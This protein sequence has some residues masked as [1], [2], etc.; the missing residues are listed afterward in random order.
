M[1]PAIGVKKSYLNADPAHRHKPAGA[2]AVSMNEEG[3]LVVHAVADRAERVDASFSTTAAAAES[4]GT[5]HEPPPPAEG[6]AS[7]AGSAP[8]SAPRGAR[9]R[10]GGR[11]RAIAL[12]RRRKSPCRLADART[13]H[14]CGRRRRGRV[15]RPP[16]SRTRSV[17]GR[18]PAGRLEARAPSRQHSA[19]N[20]CAD[21]SLSSRRSR[22][23][24]PGPPP[25]SERCSS[26]NAPPPR[27]LVR[28]S[29]RRAARR[30]PLR[31]A[32]SITMSAPALRMHWEG[33]RRSANFLRAAAQ[34][35]RGECASTRLQIS[36]EGPGRP[37]KYLAGWYF[38]L[39]VTG[40]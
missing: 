13:G 24:P 14:P 35:G 31:A 6:A 27:R 28:P 18:P 3:R 10:G 23:R 4:R 11:P 34:R 1:P 5:L 20:N 30:P 19:R 21:A 39:R 17:L 29:E 7:A 36:L 25:R 8:S 33:R 15:A 22:T 2:N 37:T 32:Q 38:G 40:P 9:A 12:E 26:S 16:G